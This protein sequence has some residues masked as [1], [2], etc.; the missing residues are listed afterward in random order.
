VP[1]S[2]FPNFRGLRNSF[3]A[4]VKDGRPHDA[5]AALSAAFRSAVRDKVGIQ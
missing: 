3:H 1:G 4:R 2:G 5:L